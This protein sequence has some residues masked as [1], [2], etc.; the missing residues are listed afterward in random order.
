ML[1]LEFS[2]R[3]ML[4]LLRRRITAIASV[5]AILS[6]KCPSISDAE[7]YAS[8]S[9]CNNLVRRTAVSKGLVLIPQLD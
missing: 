2:L 8:D 7:V 4:M 3:V 6:E 1:E 9:G 5:N